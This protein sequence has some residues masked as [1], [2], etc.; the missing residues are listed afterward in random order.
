MTQLPSTHNLIILRRP[1]SPKSACSTSSVQDENTA[2]SGGMTPL[3]VVEGPGRLGS[4]RVRCL[5]R[6]K[7]R[8]VEDSKIRHR[9]LATTSHSRCKAYE[10]DPVEK[11]NPLSSGAGAVCEHQ[12]PYSIGSNRA[13][14]KR[15]LRP[16]QGSPGRPRD[17][18]KRTTPSASR[19]DFRSSNDPKSGSAGRLSM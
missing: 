9:D 15:S 16:T 11:G 18:R 10:N 17:Q 6:A 13:C 5:R 12:L 4:Q 14:K 1:S 7:Q 2:V 3:A 19:R 8:A